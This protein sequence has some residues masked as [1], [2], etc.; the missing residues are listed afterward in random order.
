MK[1]II[2]AK[3]EHPYHQM[4]REKMKQYNIESPKQLTKDMKK[5]FFK[6]VKKTW[7]R[8]KK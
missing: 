8:M 3:K 5:V 2:C 6:D 1:I 4:F 7:E